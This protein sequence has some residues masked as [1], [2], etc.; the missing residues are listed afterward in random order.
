MSKWEQF[1]ELAKTWADRETND[2]GLKFFVV[3][4]EENVIQIKVLYEGYNK[5]YS[6]KYNK[7][8]YD[9]A[10]K[11]QDDKDILAYFFQLLREKYRF[12]SVTND[13]VLRCRRPK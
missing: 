1:V 11:V 5:R 2:A 10:S 8:E 13:Y 4:P 6:L 12:G 7:Q 9:K 3:T